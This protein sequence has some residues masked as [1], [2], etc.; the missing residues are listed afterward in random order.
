MTENINFYSKPFQKPVCAD[1]IVVEYLLKPRDSV[2]ITEVVTGFLSEFK[3]S[4]WTELPFSILRKVKQHENYLYD[5]AIN[6]Y[7]N[8]A[9]MQIAYPVV[10]FDIDFGGIAQLLSVI[11]GDNFGSKK[12][13]SIRITDITFPEAVYS[14]FKGPTFGIEGI[15]N[16][17]QVQKAPLLQMI[18]K[19]RFGLIAED[20][21]DIAYRAAIAGIDG[22][23]DDQMLI[24]TQYCSFFDKVEAISKAVE[25]AKDKTGRNIAYYPNITVSHKHIPRIIDFL[26]E[27][28]INTVTVNAIYEGLGVIELLRE[29]APDF[30]LQAHRS[31]YMLLSNNRCYSLSYA[32]LAQLLNLA[33]ADEIHVGSVFGRFDVKK[34]ETL[35]SL[36]HILHPPNNVKRSF[37]IVAGGVT[38]AIIEATMTEIGKNIVFMVGSGI[39]GHPQ[40]I[41]SGVK[42]LKEMIQVVMDGTGLQSLLANK[43]ISDDLLKAIN[44]W[45]Y[46]KDGI[47]N[48]NTIIDMA[49][50]NLQAKDYIHP[51]VVERM[52]GALYNYRDSFEDEEIDIIAEAM[53]I[54]GRIL[55]GSVG[56]ITEK[57]VKKLCLVNDIDYHQ[58]YSALEKLHKAGTL[59]DELYGHLHTIRM[60][61]NKAKHKHV[62]IFFKETVQLVN[63]LIEF[64]K[65]LEPDELFKLTG[66]YE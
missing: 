52:K 35:K 66:G 56:Q 23:R 62:F 64:F 59:D 31:G 50:R 4:S 36:S 48:D 25:R 42:A 7:S 26:R 2:N 41:Q 10:N 43:K 5:L 27:K 65:R 29:I 9:Y 34:Q 1:D 24:S 39:I 45:G 54:S 11:A 38:P 17:Y 8:Y 60:Y 30:I 63:G 61:Y 33:G 3:G 55:A 51:E 20:Y 28:K 12:I 18:L 57:Y 32:V 22:V 13:D 47:K 6:E 15:R 19:P 46:K 16:L 14:Q 53:D 37:P 21:A 58:F 49:V 40:G 44:L